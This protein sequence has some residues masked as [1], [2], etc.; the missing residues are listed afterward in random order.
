M[1]ILNLQWTEVCKDLDWIILPNGEDAVTHK[2]Q[3]FRV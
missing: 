1:T 3:S 2:E